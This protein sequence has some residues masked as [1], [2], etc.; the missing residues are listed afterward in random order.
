MTLKPSFLLATAFAVATFAG[1][2]GAQTGIGQI[3]VPGDNPMWSFDISYVDQAAQ[4]YFLA[5]RT[6]KAIDVFDAKAEKF[7]GRVGG[8][9]G[10]VYDKNGKPDNDESG[11]NGVLTIGDEAWASD[12]DGL[13][14]VIDLKTMKVT[15]TIKTGATGR[16]DEMAYD[17]KDQVFIVALPAN[18]PPF[19]TLISTKPGHKILGKVEFPDS[20]DGAEQ[21]VWNPNDGMF[22]QPVPEIH[23]NA[24]RANLSVIDPVSAKEV[25]R[26]EIDG[27]AP[28]GTAMVP[29][30][31][32]AIACAARGKEGM[33]PKQLIINP[34]SGDV[35]ATID[36][37]GGVD[38]MAYSKT[39]NQFYYGASNDPSGHV[40]GVVDAKSNK[41]V[42][43]VPIIGS[44]PHSVAV[45]E[46][47]G[48]IYVPAGSKEGGCG[49]IVVF[50]GPL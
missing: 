10:V 9:K 21:P 4:R 25:R 36:G 30:G 5:D 33:G 2:A 18:D 35:V 37:L 14:K 12:G 7:I 26:I 19:V 8:M 22:Y 15:D 13:V 3:A 41:L 43:K 31:N 45:N 49:C 47:S 48:H 34:A 6:N 39:N 1:S 28:R 27:C 17:P 50:G 16:A 24:R 42:A 29:N 38:E 20:T 40:L 46:A 44:A 23:D 32:M 11:P